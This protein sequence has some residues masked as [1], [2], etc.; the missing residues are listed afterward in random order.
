[1]GWL[2][3]AC[4]STSTVKFV[5]LPYRQL[6]QLSS[7]CLFC[8]PSANPHPSFCQL[9]P[10]LLFACK[11]VHPAACG[12]TS[13]VKFVQLLYGQLRAIEPGILGILG[14]LLYYWGRRLPSNS[15]R[16]TGW[17]HSGGKNCPY[18]S[19]FVRLS[20]YCRHQPPRRACP[21]HLRL[22]FTVCYR[23]L[24]QQK[25]SIGF[26]SNTALSWTY[27]LFSVFRRGDGMSGDDLPGDGLR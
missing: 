24:P 7:T 23:C 14:I 22:Y 27:G 20:P 25:S 3:A 11:A 6:P 13:P 17:L 10:A 21:D 26:Y 1:M 16:Y 18:S 8:N 15:A 9:Q 5:Q 2:A 4:R 12:S 19:V